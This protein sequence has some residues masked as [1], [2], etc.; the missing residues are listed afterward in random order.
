MSEPRKYTTAEIQVS[1]ALLA[2]W[3]E[4]DEREDWDVGE[5]VKT[6][7]DALNLPWVRIRPDMVA[8]S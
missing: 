5:V 7:L 3:R 1:D 8:R 2:L 6:A 4:A